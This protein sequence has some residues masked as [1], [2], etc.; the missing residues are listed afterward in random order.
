MKVRVTREGKPQDIAKWVYAQL[1]DKNRKVSPNMVT[2]MNGHTIAELKPKDMQE[3]SKFLYKLEGEVV[4]N[5]KLVFDTDDPIK[6][7][8]ISIPKKEEKPKEESKQEETGLKPGD[9]CP[10]CE[11]GKLKLYR[12][13]KQP[14][15]GGLKCPVCNEWIE[16]GPISRWKKQKEEKP[17]EDE[18]AD[19]FS[20]S[21]F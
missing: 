20:D 2:V 3:L 4:V 16:T 21:D 19:E 11:K 5:V 8:L 9:L 18:Q 12:F 15:R 6:D 17:K 14:D 1:K 7:G 13:K 10:K